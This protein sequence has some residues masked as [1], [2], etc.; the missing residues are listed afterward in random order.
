VRGTGPTVRTAVENGVAILTLDRIHANA[1]N[2][3]LVDDL[4]DAYHAAEED[5][6]VG[7]VVLT[8]AG[9]MFCPGL[10]LQELYPLDRPALARF[11][12][13]FGACV[14]TLYAFSKPVI[15]ALSGHALAGGCILALTADW[16]IARRGA[17]LGL[18][19]VKVGVPLPFGV[20]QILRESVPANR[21][22]EVAL[23][24]RNFQ[25]EAAVAAGLAHEV[26]EPD[27]FEAAWRGRA[28]EFLS[29]DLEATR[30]TKRY[31]RA[32]TI[33][34]IRGSA[35]QLEA[36]FV[37]R[38]FSEPTRR[39]VGAIVEDLGKRGKA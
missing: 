35:R 6:A 32:R 39:R 9:R 5:P 33:E 1:I 11:M 17:L 4:L 28:E 10:D 30:I 23:L 2:D 36:E 26:V 8:A 13:R 21:E 16:R 38:W 34:S 29:R 24:G 19:E 31:L 22:T 3:A 15:A 18:N 12:E 7:V 27:A 25:D 20:T 37:D 14:L